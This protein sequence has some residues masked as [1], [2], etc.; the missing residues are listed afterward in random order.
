MT[1][2]VDFMS[3][4]VSQI[5]QGGF[6]V[7]VQKCGEAA[8]MLLTAPLVLIIVLIRPL[9][10]FRFGV[11]DVTRIGSFAINLE[12]Y[13]C[14]REQIY[15]ARHMI[16]VVGC[17]RITCNRQL[18]AM[19]ER[20]NLL[21]FNANFC[22][23]MERA[24]RFW[25]RDQMHSITMH[26]S[27]FVLLATAKP[28]L[29]FS[30][31]EK[32]R[33]INL[34]EKLGIPAGAPWVCI[35]N[36]DGRYLDSR[37]PA[38]RYAPGASWAYHDHR[39]FGVETFQ[40]AAVELTNRGYHVLRMGSAAAQSLTA[41]NSMIIDYANHPLQS[42]FA[43]IFLLANCTYCIGGDSGLNLVP[44]VFRKP[45]AFINFTTI[46][47]LGRYWDWLNMP[48]L[49]KRAWHKTTHRFLTLRET[50]A[51]GLGDAGRAETYA[52]AGVEMIDNTPK[53]IL[54]LALEVDSRF[55]GAWLSTREDDYLQNRFWD[56]FTKYCP[57]RHDRKVQIR[58][59][60]LFLREHRYLLD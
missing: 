34:L 52:M 25:T 46:H 7:A 1:N 8:L 40:D 33:G 57:L 13:L 53:E 27:N 4:Q 39:N 5:K 42:D 59:G 18:Q 30:S 38:K 54:D 12:A 50:F 41:N 20:T 24:C 56:C 29:V 14:W 55:C 60:A 35:L 22:F 21:P 37:V 10:L 48:F 58:I 19:W 43:D 31:S 6:K 44:L 23:V 28:H 47:E 45:I 9:V 51:A 36:R 32:L 16:D 11:P 15:F 26:A 2:A 49:I 17:P 3:S